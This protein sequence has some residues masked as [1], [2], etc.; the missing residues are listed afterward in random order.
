MASDAFTGGTGTVTVD[1]TDFNAE[2]S[3]EVAFKADDD[4]TLYGALGLTDTGVTISSSGTQTGES[5][6][7]V[8]TNQ[9]WMKMNSDYTCTGEKSGNITFVIAAAS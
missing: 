3:N 4:K 5:G 9:L 7:T 2:G 6:D 8:A 1:V